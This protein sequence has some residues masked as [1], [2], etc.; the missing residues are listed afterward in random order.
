MKKKLALGLIL[1][2]FAV[3]NTQ[4]QSLAATYANQLVS[5]TLATKQ[6]IVAK[7][8]STGGTIDPDTGVLSSLAPSFTVST[9]K[10][11]SQ[12]LYL[13]ATTPMEQVA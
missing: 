11:S 7:G 10:A 5:A 13:T 9:N 2:G 12:T 1:S 4:S 6:S 3:L 8:T